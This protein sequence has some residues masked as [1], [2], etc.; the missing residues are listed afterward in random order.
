MRLVPI[1]IITFFFIWKKPIDF[2]LD[3]KKSRMTEIHD[4]CFR[5][6]K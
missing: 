5:G 4:T 2:R 3:G 1:I 6:A